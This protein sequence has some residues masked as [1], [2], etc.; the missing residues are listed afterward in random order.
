MPAKRKRDNSHHQQREHLHAGAFGTHEHHQQQE[1]DHQR[2]E[3][4]FVTVWQHQRLRRDFAAQ[5]AKGH[6]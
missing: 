4:H 3:V 6:D 1:R 2:R 5:F